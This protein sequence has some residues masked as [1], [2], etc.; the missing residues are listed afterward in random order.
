MIDPAGS[1]VLKVCVNV[2][3]QFSP[4]LSPSKNDLVS[5]QS[6]STPSKRLAMAKLASWVAV[7]TGSNLD[8]VGV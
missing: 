8:V 7:S 5:Y 3:N 4:E 1:K 2:I 6:T